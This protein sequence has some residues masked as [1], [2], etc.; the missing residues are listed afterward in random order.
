[1]DAPACPVTGVVGDLGAV[2]H[3]LGRRAAGVDARAAQVLALDQSRFPALRRELL[4]ERIA[5][6]ARADHDGVVRFHWRAPGLP[7]PDVQYRTRRASELW[8]FP[9]GARHDAL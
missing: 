1:M 9:R 2:D 8:V 4:P 5:R 7:Q 6:L 3:G